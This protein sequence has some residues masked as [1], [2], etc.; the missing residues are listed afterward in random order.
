M[1]HAWQPI[2]A[3]SAGFLVAD[4]GSVAAKICPTCGYAICAL[5]ATCDDCLPH[6]E[7]PCR[8]LNPTHCG[9]GNELT[10]ATRVVLDGERQM[11]GLCTVRAIL[12]GDVAPDVWLEMSAD[13]LRRLLYTQWAI[14]YQEREG[15]EI[16]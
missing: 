11:C 14:L 8:P 2:N 1:T 7:R 5:E 10:E 9:C 12:G 6:L 4:C 13:A 15:S 16:Y 3:P